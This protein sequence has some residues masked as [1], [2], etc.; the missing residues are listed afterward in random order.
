MNMFSRIG[1]AAGA[2]I[3]GGLIELIQTQVGRHALWHDFFQD[4]I[5][6]GIVVGFLLWRGKGSRP[7]LALLL[8]LVLLVPF[9]MRELPRKMSA[10]KLCRDH[11]PLLSDF[12]HPLDKYLWGDGENCDLTFMASDDEHRGVLRLETTPSQTWPSARMGRFPRDWS[13]FDRFLIDIRLA[14]AELDTV[15]GGI[16]ISDFKGM[17][18]KSWKTIQILT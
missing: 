15:S 11:F 16:L 8:V 7:G 9:Q 12:D 3:V 13:G 14:D 6:I 2:A 5:G 17:K 18:E 10:V 4:L 1:A